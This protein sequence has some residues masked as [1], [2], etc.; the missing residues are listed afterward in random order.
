MKWLRAS[1]VAGAV[2]AVVATIPYAAVGPYST[3]VVVGT[4]LVQV[5]SAPEW[6]ILETAT[7]DSA[8]GLSWTARS[9]YIAVIRIRFHIEYLGDA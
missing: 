1:A 8:A 5:I 6:E 4:S 3:Y 2:A 9:K 7:W